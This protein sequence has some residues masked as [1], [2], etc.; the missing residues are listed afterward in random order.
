[1]I[2]RASD[3]AYGRNPLGKF[4]N[5]DG[6]GK[7]VRHPHAII[8][9]VNA[10]CDVM[11][12]GITDH[13]PGRLEDCK[14]GSRN[15][16]FVDFMDANWVSTL[17]KR[18][19]DHSQKA[20]GIQVRDVPHACS[21]QQY[22][23][24]LFKEEI[25]V[26][27]VDQDKGKLL[28]YGRQT[29]REKCEFE[30][31]FDD[32]IRQHFQRFHFVLLGKEGAGKSHTA[33]WL[34]FHLN[35]PQ[36]ILTSYA[37][38]KKQDS[39]TTT[40]NAGHLTSYITVTDTKGLDALSEKF[41]CHIKRILD[42]RLRSLSVENPG[43]AMSWKQVEAGECTDDKSKWKILKDPDS[44]VNHDL[45]AHAAL[46]LIR[47]PF[48]VNDGTILYNHI[49]WDEIRALSRA[50]TN[51]KME[52]SEFN[53]MNRMVFGI[54]GAPKNVSEFRAMVEKMGLPHDDTFALTSENTESHGHED[55]Y[56]L[57]DTYVRI[58][59]RLQEKA[60][61]FFQIEVR[62][63]P[64]QTWWLSW[65]DWRSW[66]TWVM[67]NPILAILLFFAM[68]LMRSVVSA[69]IGLANGEQPHGLRQVVETAMQAYGDLFRVLCSIAAKGK[70]YMQKFLYAC[71]HVCGSCLALLP[72][73]MSHAKSYMP[74]F[75][76]LAKCY[77]QEFIRFIRGKWTATQLEDDEDD[78][79]V[80]S[81]GWNL[82]FS[83]TGTAD[84]R[85]LSVLHYG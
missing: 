38:M 14:Y 20:G 85:D 43:D 80:Y 55:P 12:Q 4:A 56:I 45:R 29:P 82:F 54:T 64:V 3:L 74:E 53:L 77:M 13:K 75:I 27:K 73:F 28:Q 41:L 46:F 34:A 17:P 84:L 68:M 79:D 63:M 50:L 59:R 36:T 51:F 7:F 67:R 52:G 10:T 15:T 5:A 81:G 39:F 72:Q 76:S 58:L 31:H 78:D 37:S 33:R 25:N 32:R 42:G 57:P 69:V 9:I 6:S 2:L 24:Y 47:V 8:A 65:F 71:Y 1:M 48:N 66:F 18:S 16:T 22:F 40:Y 60:C 23:D 49:E 21:Q 61:N 44:E 83:G 70:V 30:A 35:A 11:V 26:S 19:F 62:K